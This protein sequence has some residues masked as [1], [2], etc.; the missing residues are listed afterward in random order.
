MAETFMILGQ[1][2]Q[3]SKLNAFKQFHIARRLGPILGDLLPVMSKFKDMSEEELT[4]DQTEALAPI[5]VGL[6]KLSDEEA[7]RILFGLLDAV[8]MK[9]ETGNWAKISDGKVLFFQDLD[10]PF[11]LQAAGRALMHNLSGF[12]AALPKA[13]KSAGAKKK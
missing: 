5:L 8:A 4:K 1:E 12:F 2:L 13:S 6:S 7:N 11:L 10:L 3:V 9:Q